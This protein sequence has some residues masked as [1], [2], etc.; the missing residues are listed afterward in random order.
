MMVTE[1]PNSGE[2]RS[3][4]PISLAFPQFTASEAA[5]GNSEKASPTPRIDPIS[6]CELEQ[7][8]PR[9]QVRRFQNMAENS[10]AIIIDRLWAIF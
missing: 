8:M 7:G 1:N 9:Y 4:K 3:D 5:S 2:T 10:K 6:V